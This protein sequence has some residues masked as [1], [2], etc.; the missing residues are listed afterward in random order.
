MLR[1]VVCPVCSQENDARARFCWSCGAA[2][3]APLEAS[4]VR[5]TVT[6]LF[7]DLAGST[8]LGERLDPEAVRRLMSRYFDEMRDV[9]EA[10]GGVVEKFVGDAVMAAFRVP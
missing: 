6:V 9:V 5:K 1:V 7:T 4:E 3:A 2:L 10:H 8:A